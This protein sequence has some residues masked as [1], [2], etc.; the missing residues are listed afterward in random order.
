MGVGVW[1]VGEVEA[2]GGVCINKLGWGG[3]RECVLFRKQSGES[4]G[5][6]LGT[7]RGFDGGL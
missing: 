3:L 2:G 6:V 5:R 1:G 7:D 4:G